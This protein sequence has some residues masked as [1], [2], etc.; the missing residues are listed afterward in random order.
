MTL[1]TFLTMRTQLRCIIV[2][3]C[4]RSFSQTYSRGHEDYN[5]SRIWRGRT[6]TQTVYC[7]F[8]VQ[9]ENTALSDM[10]V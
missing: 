5:N 2:D 3:L 1:L 7:L 8:L 6:F 9:Q 4:N 10:F